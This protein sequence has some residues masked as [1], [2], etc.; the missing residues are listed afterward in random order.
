MA[1]KG[2]EWNLLAPIIPFVL[3]VPVLYMQGWE[4]V[5]AAFLIVVIPLLIETKIDRKYIDRILVIDCDEKLQI[6]RAMQRDDIT[7]KSARAVL[8]TQATRQERLTAAND[9]ITNNDNLAQLKL[10]HL[11]KE[12]FHRK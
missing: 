9:V 11:R 6:Q 12:F 7:E 1:E 2:N 5:E 3:V 4:S 8:A 10:N